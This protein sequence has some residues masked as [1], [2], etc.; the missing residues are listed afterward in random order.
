LHRDWY[1]N[2]RAGG[3]PVARGTVESPPPGFA[4]V[5]QYAPNR[6]S[7]LSSGVV[8]VGEGGRRI[9]NTGKSVSWDKQPWLGLAMPVQAGVSG[10]RPGTLEV[11]VKG[12]RKAVCPAACIRLNSLEIHWR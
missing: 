3:T 8:P 7:C 4:E 10:T 9:R 5:L 6:E 12:P 2:H 1:D 11:V